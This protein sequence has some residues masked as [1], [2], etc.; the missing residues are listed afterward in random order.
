MKT[1]PTIAAAA[2]VAATLAACGSNNKPTADPSSPS[3]LKVSHATKSTSPPTTPTSSST[4]TSSS[5]AAVTTL[6]PCQ[7]VTRGE[8]SALAQATFGP[9]REE[10][11]GV[12]K[13]CV[14]GAQTTNVLEIT[15]VQAASVAAAQAHWN[16]LLAEAQQ[17]VS[18]QAAGMVKLTPQPGLA[19]RAEW[20]EL[21]LSAIHAE[22][23]GLAFL[24]GDVGVYVI[25]LVRGAAA[26][27]RSAMTAEAQTV[28]SRLP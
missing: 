11:A 15:V 9:G 26:P 28:L 1:V 8:A 3:S 24:S 2:L 23:R 21:D 19:D 13:Q 16:Q 22:A 10:A 17:A 18:A 7:L 5:G 20:A 14:Y 27:S 6:D 4:T 25:D 12:G